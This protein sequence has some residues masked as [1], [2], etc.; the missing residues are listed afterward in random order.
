MV[1]NT[2]GASEPTTETAIAVHMREDAHE[3]TTTMMTTQFLMV[4]KDKASILSQNQPND[5]IHDCPPEQPC[6]CVNDKEELV[7]L[8][9]I[10][11]KKS[12]LM[13]QVRWPRFEASILK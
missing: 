12:A 8:N 6:E 2:N 7:D 3:K 13:I 1:S 5:P 10:G 4:V 11:R 9:E